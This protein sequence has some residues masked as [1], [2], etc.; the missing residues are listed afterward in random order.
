MLAIITFLSLRGIRLW[1]MTWQS[2]SSYLYYFGVLAS[3][4]IKEGQEGDLFRHKI[5]A[6]PMSTV[7]LVMTFIVTPFSARFD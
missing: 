5:L 3:L 6:M 1:R 2:P 7:S 4:F